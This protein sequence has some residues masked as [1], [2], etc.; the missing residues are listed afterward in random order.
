M[1]TQNG[2]VLMD[3]LIGDFFDFPVASRW[4][5]GIQIHPACDVEELEDRFLL[6]AEL[7]GVPKEAIQ[8]EVVGN[9]I[10][11]SGEVAR[12]EKQNKNG[13]LYSE[14]RFGKFMRKFALPTEVDSSKVEASFQDGILKVQLPK[15]EAAKSRQI[16]VA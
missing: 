14:R 16:K 7:P 4:S 3:H 9:Q 2:L 11:I 13:A 1:N 15:A 8:V 10:V 5:S 12:E 6:S